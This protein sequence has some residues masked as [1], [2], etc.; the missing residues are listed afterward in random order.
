MSPFRDQYETA[1]VPLEVEK[2]QIS[3]LEWLV[4]CDWLSRWKGSEV[5]VLGLTVLP[6]L[7]RGSYSAPTSLN[8]LGY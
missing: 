6:S 7:I 2:L 3:E 5:W 8:L 1:L 4:L